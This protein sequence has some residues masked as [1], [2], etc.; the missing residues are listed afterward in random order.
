[1]LVSGAGYR[2]AGLLVKMATTLDHLSG[3]RASLGLGAGWHQAEHRAFGFELPPVAGAS[4]VWMN[5]P[6][7]YAHC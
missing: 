5:R 3:G 6:P 4:T 1:M 2:N 7:R